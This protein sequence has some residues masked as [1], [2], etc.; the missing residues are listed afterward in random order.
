MDASRDYGKTG[1]CGYTV[2][3][4]LGLLCVFFVPSVH[5]CTC[6]CMMDDKVCLVLRACTL[7]T[8]I[9]YNTASAICQRG[10]VSMN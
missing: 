7:H 2:Y 1:D 10:E 3:R 6:V 5:M 9:L 8:N 4:P